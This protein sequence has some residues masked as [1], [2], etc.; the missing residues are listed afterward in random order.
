MQLFSLLCRSGVGLFFIV[1]SVLFLGLSTRTSCIMGNSNELRRLQPF[2]AARW[3]P[4]GFYSR[5]GISLSVRETCLHRGISGGQNTY[6]R[7]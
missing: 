4:S 2:A 5:N 1:S 6:F 3:D 7:L